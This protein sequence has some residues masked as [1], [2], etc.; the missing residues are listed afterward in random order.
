MSAISLP[1]PGAHEAHGEFT[2]DVTSSRRMTREDVEHFLA[3][4]HAAP[5]KQCMP[6]HD[7]GPGVV[8]R[9]IEEETGNVDIG[10]FYITRLAAYQPTVHPAEFPAHFGL[11]PAG[12]CTRDFNDILLRITGVHTHGVKLE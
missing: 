11:G 1:A 9:R 10:P 12:E 6:E 2:C 3:V 8:H 7:L 4:F 5:R